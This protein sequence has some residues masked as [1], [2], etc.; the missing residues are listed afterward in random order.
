MGDPSKKPRMEDDGLVFPPNPYLKK[1]EKDVLYH[2]G[3]AT[4][5]DDLPALFGDV[6]FV[7]MG[8]SPTRMKRFAEFI[9]KRLGLVQKNGSGPKDL[10]ST[11]RY[12]MYKVGS[13][14]SVSHGMGMP[15]ISILLHELIKLMHHA[16]CTDVIFTR[17][18]TCG[19]LGL[20]PG[21]VVITDSA[22]NEM[23]QPVYQ[24]I[25]LGK[26]VNRPTK[27]SREVAEEIRAA[28]E[29]GAKYDV[30]I[31]N[32]MC[33]SDF[34]EGQARIDGA[35]CD[36]TLEDKIEYL[37]AAYDAGVRNIEMEG[38][39]LAAMCHKSGIKGAVVCV[40]LLDRLLG[41]QVNMTPE[42][43]DEWEQ[44][45]QELMAKFISKRLKL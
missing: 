3:L 19:G 14:L 8:G 6:K 13:V 45:P 10:C 37:K 7:C 21:T 22:V 41:D 33:T 17:M 26:Q 27:L 25:V 12:S 39:C 24:M 15:S 5:K 28:Y 2:L 42:E 34:Y 40:T 30:V 4:D 23:F 16:A 31:G 36:H 44:R 35:I 18:G 29:P 43:H 20:A 11:D 9:G 1:Q 38:T 32:T